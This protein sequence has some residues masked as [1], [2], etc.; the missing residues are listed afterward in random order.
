MYIVKAKRR[1]AVPH[2]YLYGILYTMSIESSDDVIFAVRLKEL[3]EAKGLSQ[4]DLAKLA[5]VQSAMIS[6]FENGRRSPSILV[7]R[8][9]A[10]L[11]SVPIDFL[12]GRSDLREGVSDQGSGAIARI[13]RKVQGLS[14]E[15]Q[16]IAERLI[17][18]LD[19]DE[20]DR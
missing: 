12:L 3:R 11:F 15:K 9:L 17:D 8:R 16:S 5:K 13:H 6:H 20:K 7:L 14:L 2:A 19:D 1:R 18:A 10:D 4:G